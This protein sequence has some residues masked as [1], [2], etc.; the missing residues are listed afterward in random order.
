MCSA[1]SLT[2]ASSTVGIREEAG[3]DPIPKKGK[4]I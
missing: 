2:L 3:H 4:D 1:A